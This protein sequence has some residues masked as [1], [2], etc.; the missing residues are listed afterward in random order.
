MARVAEDEQ[1][2]VAVT[3]RSNL[4]G[5]LEFSQ[6]AVAAGL[7]PIIGCKL[8]VVLR[9][10]EP[11]PNHASTQAAMRANP[12]LVFLA[13]DQTGYDNLTKLASLAHMEGAQESRP[14]VT[15]P[16]MRDHTDG[17]I[18]L[19]GGPSGPLNRAMMDGQAD[20]AAEIAATL[21][22]L[23]RDRLYIELQRHRGY[24]RT[25]EGALLDMAYERDIALVATNEAYFPEAQDYEAHDVL[26]CIAEGR[27]VFEEDR[28]K[29]TAD[30]YLK[31]SAEMALLFADLPEALAN[32]LVIAE[33]CAFS[34]PE[35]DPILPFFTGGKGDDPLAAE[36]A[37]LVVQARAG[38]DERLKVH[39][40]APGFARE[41]YDA[42]LE[43]E[44]D[45]IT[46]MKFPGYFLIV[47]DFIK[48]AKGKGIPV[49][50]GRG[51]GAGS[52]VAWALTVTD[53]DP[54]R[55][56]LLFER[57]LNPERVSMPD[58]DIDFCQDRRDEVIRYVQEK[59]GRAQVA[60]I[61][62]FGTLQAR[63]VL[64][65]VGRVLEMPYGQVDKLCK[66]VPNN[67]ANPT[68]LA[69]ALES[70]TELIEARRDPDVARL[71]ALALKLEGLY[72]HAST[73][74][75]GIVIGDREL[76]KLVPLY[77]DPKSDMP[78]TQFNMKYVE[79]AGLVK[80]DF[81]G[82]KTLTVIRRA[83]EFIAQKGETVDVDGLK[84]T[85]EKTFDMLQRGETVGVFQLESAGMRKALVGMKPDQFEDIIALVALYRPGPMDNI[86]TYNDR[87]HGR[88]E[89]DY[90]EDA[91][92]DVL[93]ETYG[94]IIYQ[95]QVM[96]IA[97]ILSGFSLGEADLLR[98]AMGKK[99]A[100]EM[101]KQRVRFNDGAVERGLTQAR[102]NFIFDV[103]A[104]FADY[105][106]N[107]SHAAAYALISYQ[108]A[109]LKANYP[110]EFAAALMSL[111][112]NNTDK[113]HDFYRE[114]KRT[115]I[116]VV[117]PS[118]N[119]SAVGFSVKDNK[120]FYALAGIKGVGAQAM[121]HVVD[122][123]EAGGPFTSITNFFSRIDPR[124]VNRKALENLIASG[125]MDCFGCSREQ[126]CAG[127]D[128]LVGHATRVSENSAMGIVDMFGGDTGETEV[129]L[130]K[131][132]TWRPAERLLR[133][134]QALGFY[135]SAHPL[136]EYAEM[137]RKM[138]V[139]DWPSFERDVRKGGKPREIAGTISAVQKRRTRSGNMMANVLLSEPNGQFEAAMFSEQLDQYRDLLQVGTSVLMKVAA[140]NEPE[141]VQLRIGTMQAL[142]DVA[143]NVEH[144]L[145][146][147]V[148]D[149]KPL[150]SIKR[151]V[152]GQG[153][154]QVSLIVVRG[155]GAPEVEIGLP[156]KRLI[157][158]QIAGAIKAIPGVVD[159]QLV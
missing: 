107:K 80:F 18:V 70:E 125:A 44:L 115:D 41:D 121:R 49:G 58:F 31:S 37:E 35:R 114:A 39:D 23:Y 78:V 75:A 146:I 25:V 135:M 142:D 69:Q 68:T 82:L 47:A 118:V 48:W 152:D 50:P 33:R 81:L 64:R 150:A 117:P 129:V 7:Q 61:I 85:D 32:T 139:R 19:T 2:A 24:D 110:V 116:K 73:H 119:T 13:M 102:S 5:A 140:E 103:L 71:I 131:A 43:R 46:G 113:L 97:Q 155:D 76:D 36:A 60:Q 106:F 148:R 149:D 100:S 16:Q 132:D 38:L 98:R 21:H 91:I 4:F 17:L 108:T 14:H 52:L 26:L 136:D 6:K 22:D 51:S 67:P 122:Q 66:L 87:K 99:I 77:R 28:R 11:G 156:G 153:A 65:D 120:V 127:I 9:E 151:R 84:L 53:L 29:L 72:R 157:S 105:G 57:F 109:W 74:A 62:T 45:I 3:D 42:R 20:R 123:R 90:Y 92:A 96:Q 30:H 86:P 34:V 111:D 95:E 101:E 147:F 133:E 126:M 1:P 12:T 54:L 88:E 134:F 124:Q 63:A 137:L 56:A 143:K 10:A 40:L 55:F 128:R 145:S 27:K 104:K 130:P 94:V 8:E 159:V 144:K 59:Y 158:P 79:Q 112:M 93:R 15:L 89:P 83:V 154:G 141:G 138:R